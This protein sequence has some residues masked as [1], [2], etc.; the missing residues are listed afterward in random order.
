MIISRRIIIRMKN[1]PGILYGE[2]QNTY[3]MFNNFFQKSCHLW[4]NLEKDGRVFCATEENIILRM[5]FARLTKKARTHTHKHTHTHTHKHI[6]SQNYTHTKSLITFNTYC[7]STAKMLMLTPLNFRMTV[8]CQSLK[9][10]IQNASPIGKPLPVAQYW[11]N[12]DFHIRS[13]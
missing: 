3:F 4:S 9:T 11:R 12:Q 5:C 1:M 7:F 13:F 8:H 6:R 10:P 2:K